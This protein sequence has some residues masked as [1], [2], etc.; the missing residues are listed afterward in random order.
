MFSEKM[1]RNPAGQV[2]RAIEVLSVVIDNR[3]LLAM[4]KRNFVS[5][6]IICLPKC[7]FSP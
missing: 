4:I 3:H 2:D 6:L 7:E 1:G 5:Y